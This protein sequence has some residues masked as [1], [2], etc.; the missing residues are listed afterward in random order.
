[1]DH[2]QIM[3][4]EPQF[5]PEDYTVGWLCAI[6]ESE[7]TAARRMLDR[8]HTPP[9]VNLN[10][11]DRNTYLFGEIH[12]HNVVITC[13]PPGQTGNV[14]AQRLVSPL[15]QSFPRLAIHFFVG[16]GGG[17]PRYPPPEDPFKDIHLGDVVVGWADQTGVP[18]IVQHDHTRE[19][20]GDQTD[21]LGLLDKP[22]L[23]VLNALNP[24]IS[25]RVMKETKF[26]WNLKKLEDL[27]IF[28]HPGLDKDI[29]FEA[30]YLHVAVKG[31]DGA[32]SQC[33]REHLAKRQ[34][35]NTTDPQFHQGTILSGESVIN[36]AQK[37]DQL[38]KKYYNAKCIEMEAAGVIDD[39]HCLVIRGISDY[40]D[41]HKPA[42]WE[43]YA[44]ATA[45]AFAREILSAIR[46]ALMD[47]IKSERQGM[48]DL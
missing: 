37:R 29:L 38:S 10:Q 30:D 41:G 36:N 25:D 14:S 46:P 24:I 28:Q 26:H 1:M 13:M 3:A 5:R 8:R 35:R 31:D 4:V 19:R 20:D 6:A 16:I 43:Y 15:Q 12:G 27:E 7:L 9:P 45:A 17:I 23:Q 21:L 18:G 22:S 42:S 40:A 48:Q 2:P 32:C 47:K 33:G 44:A 34:P 11:S 39:T